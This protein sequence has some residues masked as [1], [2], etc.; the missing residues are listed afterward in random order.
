MNDIILPRCSQYP[1]IDYI[2]QLFGFCIIQS[3][4]YQLFNHWIKYA[5]LFNLLHNGQR[6]Y[7]IS[8]VIIRMMCMHIFIVGSTL[9]KQ[10]LYHTFF[11]RLVS[12]VPISL[13]F[14]TRKEPNPLIGSISM[15]KLIKVVCILCKGIGW[16]CIKISLTIS[17]HVHGLDV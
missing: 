15:I 9:S 14:F 11:S 7:S 5:R 8:P 16:I 6:N 1:P 3:I 13:P 4:F 17:L 12:E 10:Y 2:F